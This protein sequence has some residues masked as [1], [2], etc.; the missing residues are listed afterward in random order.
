VRNRRHSVFTECYRYSCRAHGR[1]CLALPQYRGRED[2]TLHQRGDP[3]QTHRT[4]RRLRRVQG[5][6][7]RGRGVLL[8]CSARLRPLFGLRGPHRAALP[9]RQVLR[10]PTAATY[11]RVSLPHRGGPQFGAHVQLQSRR[12]PRR[13]YMYSL[14]GESHSGAA[15]QVH[16]SAGLRSMHYM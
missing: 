3:L 10:Q 5:V 14:Q 8:H 11:V 16:R 6:P 15:I 4:E 13:R 2:E 12:D 9:H 1:A 7:H